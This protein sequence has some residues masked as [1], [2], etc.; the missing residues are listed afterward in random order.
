VVDW[1]LKNRPHPEHGYRRCL[2][3]LSLSRRYGKPRLEAACGRAVT[4]RTLSYRS[5]K[6]ILQQGLDQLPA[7]DPRDTQTA[8]PLHDN[9]RGSG[10]YS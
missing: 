9:V 7:E 10:Y 5:V 3:L 1:L 4:Q 8:L 2:G 6:S